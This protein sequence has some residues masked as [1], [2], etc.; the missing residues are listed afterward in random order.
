MHIH[1]QKLSLSVLSYGCCPQLILEQGEPHVCGRGVFFAMFVIAGGNAA[2]MER[3]AYH[4][5]EDMNDN[6]NATKDGH[7]DSVMVE[8]RIDVFQDVKEIKEHKVDLK[9][10]T[11][12]G[13][14]NKIVK[15]V[16]SWRQ[17]GITWVRMEPRAAVLTP[18]TSDELSPGPRKGE[19]IG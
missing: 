18:N 3:N 14:E 17:A 1:H 9:L 12:I 16:S 11:I 19:I 8:L 4:Q 15:Q 10:S 5:A 13:T 6:F 7:T 2:A